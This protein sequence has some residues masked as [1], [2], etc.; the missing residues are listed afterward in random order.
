MLSKDSF[1]IIQATLPVVKANGEKITRHFYARMFEH[2]PALKNLFNMGNQ[3]S[4][5][6]A[7]ALANA[8]YGYAAN[9]D[10]QEIIDP[11][12]NRI[13]HKHV[14]LGITPAQYTIV[15]RH[16]LSS[17]KEVLGDA[18]TPS[19]MAAWDEAY[20]LMA[21]D[22]IAREARHYQSIHWNPGQ[23]WNDMEVVEKIHC[24]VDVVSLYLRPKNSHQ[25]M[26]FLPGQYVSV[27]LPVAE[28]GLTQNRQ[29]SLSNSPLEGVW[30]ITVKREQ[31]KFGPKGN[32]SNLIY[33]QLA[34]GNSILVG[35]PAGEFVVEDQPTPI[36]LLSAGIGIT[37]MISIL[38]DLAVHDSP[39]KIVFAHATSQLENIP[40][41][42][43][44]NREVQNLS[45]AQLNLWLEHSS[46]N[47]DS[48]SGRMDL[49][50]LKDLPLDADFYICGPMPFIQAQKH[51]LISAG[52]C[53]N[54]I[55]Y[56]AFG[57]DVFGGH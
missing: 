48:F 9:I 27:C 14:S 32:V 39:R 50:Q 35:P 36:V 28:L 4:G 38:R 2:H 12:L 30:R 24:A 20:W 21:C 22:L 42:D 16:L 52:V 41:L 26:T 23:E 8:V 56:E 11:I 29:Y 44:I 33:D 37:P 51:W 18:V 43:E 49:S 46:F 40:H 3:A 19:V 53:V 54:K 47:Y 25:P 1:P 10:K 15:G 13:A 45:D 5:E 17:I 6:Q 31:P 55:H 34:V 7:Q 57:P